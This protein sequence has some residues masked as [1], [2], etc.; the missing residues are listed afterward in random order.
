[1]V[2]TQPPRGAASHDGQPPSPDRTDFAGLIR[3][4][5]HL[6]EDA[7]AELIELDGRSRIA[8]GERVELRRYFDAIPNLQDR[9]VALDAAIDMTLR[10]L[11][12]SSAAGTD[13]VQTLEQRYPQ[14]AGA[15]RE[16]AAL[17]DAL[18]STSAL[19]ARLRPP[20]PL[21]L[22]AELG[23]VLADGRPRYLLTR[24][25][26]CGSQG[27]VYLA[28][29]RLLSE[30]DMAAQ[31]AIKVL[32]SS[33]EAPHSRGRLAEEATKARRINHPNVV[34]VLDRGVTPGNDEYIVYEYV[35]GGDLSS[36]L[37]KRG[38]PLE[39]DLAI[40]LVAQVARGVHSAHAA[41]LV[42]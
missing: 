26:G 39:T 5:G 18:C 8:L 17:S 27:Q 32:A 38:L 33:L 20:H 34:R 10:S 7:L 30:P 23:T 12:A 35:P 19:A 9:V 37:L 15:I 2:R 31:V 41:G 3:S 14:V 25:L 29:D 1:M 36:F 4:R 13:F 11:A 42:H 24:C 6:T 16:A 28:D 40:R 21:M 22:P